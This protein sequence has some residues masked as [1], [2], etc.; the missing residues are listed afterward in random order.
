MKHWAVFFLTILPISGSWFI[1]ESGDYDA[2]PL[3]DGRLEGR[4]LQQCCEPYSA[5]LLL[6]GIFHLPWAGFSGQ[7]RWNTVSTTHD[8][9]F[10][11]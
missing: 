9:Q 1:L 5:Y 4:N 10:G 7:L 3:V 8:W 11:V 2:C 6:S